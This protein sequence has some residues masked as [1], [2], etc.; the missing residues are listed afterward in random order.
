MHRFRDLLLLLPLL[1]Y[2][3]FLAHLNPQ[4][5]PDIPAFLGFCAAFIALPAMGYAALV[6]PCGASP[7]QKVFLGS[8]LAI[9]TLVALA[10]AQA[11]TRLPS[12]LWLQP[13]LGAAALLAARTRRADAPEAPAPAQSTPRHEAGGASPWT[14]LALTWGALALALVFVGQK[15]LWVT[16]AAPGGPVSH[17]VDDMGMAS[18]VFAAAR[19]MA[20]G[21]PVMQCA[22][23]DFPLSYHLFYHYTYAAA[24]Q[25]A[26]AHPVAQVLFLF[27]PVLVALFI[28][29][30]TAGCRVLARFSPGETLLA[31]LL[32]VFGAG[33]GFLSSH[34]IQIFHY[35]HTYLFGLPALVL[36]LA[37]IYGYLSQRTRRLNPVYVSLCYFAACGSKANLL[38]LLPL[39]LLPVFA[40]RLLKRRLRLA[41]ALTATGCV[42]AAVALKFMLYTNSA[43]AVASSSSLGKILFKSMGNLRE[44]L[45]VCG[46]YLALMLFAADA[47]A[48]IRQ[49]LRDSSGYTLFA[50]TFM[51]ASSVMLKVFN[52]VGGDQYFFWHARLIV[53]LAFVPVAAHILRRRTKGYVVPVVLI[54]ALSLGFSVEY[55]FPKNITKGAAR[56]PMENSLTQDERDGLLWAYRNLDHSQTFFTNRD[57]YLGFYMG[58]YIRNDFFDYLAFSGLQG[59]AWPTTDLVGD[60]RATAQARYAD[61]QGFLN[62]ASQ[63][64]AIRAL[65]HMSARYYLHDNLLAPVQ[66]PPGLKEIHRTPALVIYENEYRAR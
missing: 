26:G 7:A 30:V 16:P 54:V 14:D 64:D 15:A 5:A 22:L 18:Y 40:L 29:S 31:V 66:T 49:K 32:A 53:V 61:E 47:N 37:A 9:A 33:Y 42:A 21:L 6:L 4:T 55:L 43:R 51:A 46:V 50:I 57:H 45:V 1:A 27:P 48:A 56:N 3:A 58:T 38:P 8:P 65:S 24:M 41:E 39:S 59:Y 34:T 20:E 10:W 11:A 13:A 2:Y 19:A 36:F 25:I 12:L 17:Y 60:M 44:M 28:G 62:A 35:Q 52:F 23:A 63:E